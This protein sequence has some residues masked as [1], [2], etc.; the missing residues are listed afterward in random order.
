MGWPLLAGWAEWHSCRM[1]SETIFLEGVP[2]RNREVL[3]RFPA[4]LHGMRTAR[5]P[6]PRLLAG[7]G[8][9][10]VLAFSF[11]C[12]V[13]SAF[14]TAGLATAL[15]NGPSP[16]MEIFLWGIFAAISALSI[17]GNIRFWTKQDR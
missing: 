17:Y 5:P 13:L 2:E 4:E 10:V 11:W 15:P 12:L 6:R 1:L 14:V 7:S 8:C 9:V 3:R 16:L